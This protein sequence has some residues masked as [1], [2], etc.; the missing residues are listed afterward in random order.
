MSTPLEPEEALARMLAI[1]QARWGPLITSSWFYD[2]D[3][4]PGCEGDIDTMRF[5]GREAI[6]LN[7]FIYRRRRVLIGYFLCSRCAGI[8]FMAAHKSPNTKTT[9]HL[10]IEERLIRAY[11]RHLIAAADA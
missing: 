9:L 3:T 11:E 10:A 6:S 7:T 5:K 1:A 8:V 2:Q 4:C